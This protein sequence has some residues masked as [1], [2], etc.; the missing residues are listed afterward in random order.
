MNA[1]KVLAVAGILMA[2]CFNLTYSQSKKEYISVEETIELAKKAYFDHAPDEDIAKSKRAN[3]SARPF[4]YK[5]LMDTTQKKFW[6]QV[7][8]AFAYL[9]QD[10]DAVKLENFLKQRR[11]ILYGDEYRATMMVFEVL[12]S[13]CARGST[14]AKAL[15]QKMFSAEYW[16]NSQFSRYP[17]ETPAEFRDNMILRAIRG[18]AYSGDPGFEAIVDTISQRYFLLV[19][20]SEQKTV[21]KKKLEDIKQFNRQIQG[22]KNSAQKAK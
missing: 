11:G 1:I 5:I 4:L 13:M 20:G 21:M 2:A 17:N 9:G 16:N 22:T 3:P 18:Y 14:T 7:L 8:G 19:S 10:D 15:Q 6:P 12:G